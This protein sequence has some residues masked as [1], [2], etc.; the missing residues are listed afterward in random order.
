MLA[1]TMPKPENNVLLWAC[2]P[3]PMKKSVKAH[4]KDLGYD[5]EN[6]FI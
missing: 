5:I 3:K 4:L 2:G 1:E 6:S